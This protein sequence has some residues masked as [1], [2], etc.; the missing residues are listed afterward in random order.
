MPTTSQSVTPSIPQVFMDPTTQK[1]ILSAVQRGGWTASQPTP[2][3]SITNDPINGPMTTVKD[4]SMVISDPTSGETQ[5]VTLNYD[6]NA[7]GKGAAWTPVDLKAGT[8]L[9][10]ASMTGTPNSQAQVINGQIWTPNP[11]DP[12]G[13]WLSRAIDQGTQ[14]KAKADLLK[15]L[16]DTGYTQAWADALA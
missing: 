2:N 10:K 14:D 9:P 5:V 12:N 15:T 3:V 1:Q 13:P 4:Y 16:T 6:P 7:T 8:S 11:N